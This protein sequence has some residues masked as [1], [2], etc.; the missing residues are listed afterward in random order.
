MNLSH[1]GEMFKVRI[2]STDAQHKGTERKNGKHEM[3]HTKGDSKSVNVVEKKANM[4]KW[5]S[6]FLRVW[7]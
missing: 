7:K 5:Q 3:F 2:Y 1:S 6:S 4:V